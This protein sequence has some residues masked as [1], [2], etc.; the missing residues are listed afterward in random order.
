LVA[1]ADVLAHPR[2]LE[3]EVVLKLVNVHDTGQGDA[4]FLKD[5]ILLVE[6]DALDHGTKVDTSLSERE[7]LNGRRSFYCA[8]SRGQDVSFRID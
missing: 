3:F 7:A 1:F 6:M 5:E 8:G 2:V 4:V